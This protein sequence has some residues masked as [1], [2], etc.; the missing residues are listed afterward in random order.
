MRH[1]GELLDAKQLNDKIQYEL[2]EFRQ[3][4][5]ESFVHDFTRTAVSC[6]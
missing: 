4:N 1:M 2:Q 5:Y 3:V 6:L